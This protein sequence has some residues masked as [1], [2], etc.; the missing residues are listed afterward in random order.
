MKSLSDILESQS[1]SAARRL[2]FEYTLVAARFSYPVPRPTHFL[3]S[4]LILNGL[5]LFR[6]E[7]QL[8]GFDRVDFRR[9]DLSDSEIEG[10]SMNGAI[11]VDS[12]LSRARWE[13]CELDETDFKGSQLVG[14][15]WRD[16]SFLGSN[17]SEQEARNAHF[18]DCQMG[19][20]S[21]KSKLLS[22]SAIVADREI[23]QKSCSNIK[24]SLI[25]EDG[26]RGWVNSC[27]LSADG[28][29]VLSSSADH[30]LKLWDSQSGECLKTYVNGPDQ[31]T[32][33]WDS[34]QELI[35]HSPSAHRWLIWSGY[36][37]D[38][39]DF[40]TFPLEAFPLKKSS[41]A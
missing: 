18:V 16:C 8:I 9:T 1:S 6:N 26:H 2:A 36:D 19:E 12:N 22:R 40:R 11:I 21:Y 27:A 31:E 3:L 14:S 13:N 4:D 37:P 25:A 35:V 32:W 15:R 30:T 7:A 38:L 23:L 29:R 33:C 17:I 34:R 20:L 39:G 28:N 24:R 5:K 41:E 10:A